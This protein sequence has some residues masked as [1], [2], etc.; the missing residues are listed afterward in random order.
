MNLDR[1]VL[2]LAGSMVL[3]SALMAAL[4]SS[5]WLLLTAFVGLNLLQSSFTGFCPAALVFRRFG[6]TSGCAFR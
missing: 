2:T 6:V 3:V 5:W 1:A 4:V